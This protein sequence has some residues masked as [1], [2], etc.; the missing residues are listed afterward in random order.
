MN[1]CFCFLLSFSFVHFIG[2]LYFIDDV[3]ETLAQ[4][5]D[6]FETI[7]LWK[8]LARS[9]PEMTADYIKQHLNRWKTEKIRFA[10][11]G[12]SAAGKSTFINIFRGVK[13]GQ[14]GSADVGFGNTGEKITEYKHP[15]N[16]NIIFCDVPGLSMKFDKS[17]F[18]KMVKLSSYNYIFLFFDSVLSVDDEWLMVQIQKKRIPFCLVR[19][20][21]DNDVKSDKGITFGEKDT[22]LKI[23]QRIKDSLSDKKAFAKV[24]LFLISSEK[25]G[26]GEMSKLQDHIKEKLPS[27]QYSAVML[28]LPILTGA[29][30]EKK[31][32][33]LKKRI[34]YV[35]VGAAVISCASPIITNSLTIDLIT[36]E[37]KHY[38]K[39]FGLD[40]RHNENI[41][42][43]QYD[44]S[45]VSVDEFALRKIIANGALV[46]A[47]MSGQDS[48]K[49]VLNSVPVTM[50]K[51]DSIKL[52]ARET[53]TFVDGFLFKILSELRKDAI[54]VHLH[55]LKKAT[56]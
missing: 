46:P 4:I 32:I 10:V 14:E 15:A 38:V 18:Q 49:L 8:K 24:E 44:F 6:R 56:R 34:P 42:G 55:Y 45:V 50:R 37:V 41:E 11:L 40:Q 54:T 20:K 29:V 5:C 16:E 23:R 1:L 12:R 9:G 28:C 17:K 22:L 3:D 51:Q 35:S 39:V 13:E 19:S 53:K 48:I 2:L 43:L 47:T 26:I 21:V 52:V 31:L 33:E 7:D 27:N 36:S 30:V 25:P